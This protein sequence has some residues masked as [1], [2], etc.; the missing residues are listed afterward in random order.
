[1]RDYKNSRQRSSENLPAHRRS[2]QSEYARTSGGSGE[3]LE[4][5][6]TAATETLDKQLRMM[7]NELERISRSFTK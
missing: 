1:M 7:K 4:T 5:V 3:R 2:T 6:K